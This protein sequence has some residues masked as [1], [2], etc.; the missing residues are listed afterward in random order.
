MERLP[1]FHYQLTEKSGNKKTGPICLITSCRGTCSR[2]CVLRGV[3]YVEYGHI[4]IHLD[5]VDA[6]ERGVDLDTMLLKLRALPVDTLFRWGDA[7]DLAG[8]GDVLDAQALLEL[9]CICEERNLR[10]FAYTHKD[11]LFGSE[12]ERNRNLLKAVCEGQSH[13]TINLS[14]EGWLKA[15]VLSCLEVGPV[16]TVLPSTMDESWR[17]TWTA[18]GRKI[19]RCPA[20][21]NP[22][23]QCVSCGGSRGPICWQKDRDF[24]VGFTSHGV[25]RRKVDS[26]IWMV[27]TQM[28]GL[29]ADGWDWR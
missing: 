22:R 20:E 2:L 24:I 1:Q 3:C 6:G 29:L 15:D 23:V 27:E 5:K 19:V 21:Y 13:F 11:V 25:F 10:G 9:V 12:A 26:A 28:N 4:R 7:G 8:P 14:A 17:V 16:A 18:A